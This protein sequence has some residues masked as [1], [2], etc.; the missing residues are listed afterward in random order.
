MAEPP[1]EEAAPMDTGDAK[2]ENAAAAANGEEA[3]PAAME[4]EKPAAEAP[5]PTVTKKKVKRTDVPVKGAVH[6]L[7]ALDLAEYTE[8]ENAMRRKDALEEAT[9]GARNDLEGYILSSRSKLYDQWD[10]YV[11]EEARSAFS[12]Q[13]DTM[14]DWGPD[15]G[16]GSGGR[17][18]WPGRRR[19]EGGLRHVR[20]PSHLRGR[21]VRAHR[22]RGEG[23]GE[24][25]VRGRARVARGQ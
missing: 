19:P 10:K 21:E 20:R 22:S 15:R 9:K 16:A 13:L 23:Q 3:A 25:R 17:H 8:K 12:K 11:A 7:T 18:A 2:D 4:T 1:T 5:A 14:G 24:Q 6:G